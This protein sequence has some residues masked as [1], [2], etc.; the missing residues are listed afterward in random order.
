MSQSN[1]VN[2][3]QNAACNTVSH[4][5]TMWELSQELNK[6]GSHKKS[7]CAHLWTTVH[8]TGTRDRQQLISTLPLGTNVPQRSANHS[9]LFT[10]KHYALRSPMGKPARC[11]WPSRAPPPQISAT[12]RDPCNYRCSTSLFDFTRKAAPGA[13]GEVN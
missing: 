12:L 9:C 13:S 11:S 5:M 4:T 7:T 6:K 2:T 8:P 1:C 3:S 10:H